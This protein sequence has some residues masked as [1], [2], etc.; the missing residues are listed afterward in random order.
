MYAHLENAGITACVV[1]ALFIKHVP[2]RET[3]MLDSEWLA[4]LARLGSPERLACWAALSP[5]NH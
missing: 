5:G 4:V 1:N 3:Y 2:G